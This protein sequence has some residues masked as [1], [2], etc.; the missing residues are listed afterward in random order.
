V[1]RLRPRRARADGD[2]L[3]PSDHERERDPL[4]YDL[5]RYADAVTRQGEN[6]RH[7]IY[8]AHVEGWTDLAI[9]DRAG[10]TIEAV[11]STIIRIE[12]LERELYR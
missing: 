5:A 11:Q 9:A 4:G 7:A 10:I 1:T 2:Q 12:T 3:R 8:K 6:L